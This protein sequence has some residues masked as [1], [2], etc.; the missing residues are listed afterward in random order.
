MKSKEEIMMKHCSD[1][2]LLNIHLG[3][4]II[5]AMEEYAS[6]FQVELSDEEIEKEFS[7]A[8]DENNETSKSNGYK[9]IENRFKQQG[10]MWYR[11]QLRKKKE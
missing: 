7:T 5:K 8:Y 4:S 2:G 3:K 1:N 6:Q 10:A 11:E 9:V